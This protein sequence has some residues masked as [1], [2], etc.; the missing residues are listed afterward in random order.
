MRYKIVKEFINMYMLPLKN[1]KVKEYCDNVFYH[2]GGHEHIDKSIY[3][4]KKYISESDIIIDVGAANGQEYDTTWCFARAFPE[5]RVFAFE[6]IKSTYMELEKNTKDLSNVKCVNKAIS[7][8][9]G[10]AQFNITQ[11][12]TSSSL[13]ETENEIKPC[14]EKTLTTIQKVMVNVDTLDDFLRTE[15]IKGE[16]ALLKLDVQGAELGALEGA[17][18]YIDR[19]KIV[20]MEMSNH[21]GYAGGCKYYEL[22]EFMRKNGFTLYYN[23]SDSIDLEQHIEWDSIYISKKIL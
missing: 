14:F 10:T 3:L 18:K 19:V 12:I 16:I 13:L 17:R 8:F 21:D 4:A 2:R 11:N 7:N 1:H 15:N 23:I 22:D 20:T 9:Q 5:N 6:P